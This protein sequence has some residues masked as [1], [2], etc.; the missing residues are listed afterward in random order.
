M[1]VIKSSQRH[2]TAVAPVCRI[3][4]LDHRA[5][6]LA[7][8][9]GRPFA[10]RLAALEEIRREYHRWKYHD[11]EPGFQRVYTIIEW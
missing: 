9:R 5:D 10:E 8:W 1:R 2:G 3:T 11:A 7:F 4:G 6:D